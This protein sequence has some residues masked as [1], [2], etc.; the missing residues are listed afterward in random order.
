M[1]I[2][3]FTHVNQFNN[4]ENVEKKVEF[5]NISTPN[6]TPNHHH[7]PLPSHHTTN[8]PL[9]NVVGIT[10]T[11]NTTS[12]S[13]LSNTS[14]DYWTS[15]WPQKH[16]SF[17]TRFSDPCL[18]KIPKKVLHAV[19]YHTPKK[20]LKLVHPNSQVA[21]EI[22]LL[23]VSQLT[24]TYFEWKNGTNPDGWKALYSKYLRELLSISPVTYIRAR[25]ALES[26]LF[27]DSIIECDYASEIGSKCYLYRLG[28]SYIGKGIM[29]YELQTK[30]VQKL[31]RE[32]Y[33][34]KLDFALNNAISKCLLEFYDR[35]NLPTITEIEEHGK[36]LIKNGYHTKKGKKLCLL[37]KKSRKSNEKNEMYSYLE[38]GIEIYQYLTETGL[39]IPTEGSYISGG[40]IVDSFTLMPSYIRNMIK[41]DGK[42]I[43]EC[44]YSCF[45]PNIAIAMYGGKSEY[46][47][48]Q[49]V[50]DEAHIDIRTVK[51][52]HLSFFNKHPGEMKDS[53][54]YSYYMK[55]EPEMMKNIIREKYNHR[56]KYKITAHRMMAKEVEIMKGVF[57]QFHSEGISAG[58]I[59]DAIICHPDN[60]QRIKEIMDDQVMKHGVFTYAKITMPA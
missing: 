42:L 18:I 17:P 43:A 48:H 16:N 38:D 33:K 52:E 55:E 31:A 12:N 49:Q 2:A 9:I 20:M 34:R 54:L 44:D 8:H 11:T 25:E 4:E 6:P 13:T 23:F 56:E 58:Y 19:K 3:S 26:R 57:S 30:E 14:E 60:S 10:H 22:C 59:Y 50:A 40:R 51:K 46:M 53:P 24:S 39:K 15:N 5:Y 27:E 21:K 35:L 29:E 47:T 37:N 36:A 28:N 7:P 32:N 41:V 45:H 1:N